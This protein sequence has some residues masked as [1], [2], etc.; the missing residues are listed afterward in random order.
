LR[1]RKAEERLNFSDR[2][3]TG[4][5]SCLRFWAVI[6][7]LENEPGLS[8]EERLNFSGR[9]SGRIRVLE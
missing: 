8:E 1:G 2:L 3:N 6:R 9:L 5:R 7:S 4:A